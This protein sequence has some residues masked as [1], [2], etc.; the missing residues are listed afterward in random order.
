M[1]DSKPV[2][3]AYDGEEFTAIVWDTELGKVITMEGKI[4]P[5]MDLMIKD[6]VEDKYVQNI[7]L[8]NVLS[9]IL[10]YKQIE[11]SACSARKSL[12]LSP[13]GVKSTGSTLSIG[14]FGA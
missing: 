6:V 12:T 2:Y 13:E 7:D 10:T 11:V 8:R 3:V 14:P 5:Q 1:K 4:N 9:P